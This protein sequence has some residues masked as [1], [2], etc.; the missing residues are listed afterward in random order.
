[1]QA[2]EIKDL[3][4]TFGGL[5]ALAEVNLGV[6]EWEIVGLIGPNGAGKTTLF[7]CMMGVY[8]PSSGDV[9]YNGGSISGLPT[10]KRA[11]LGLGRTFQNVGLAKRLTVLDNMLIA[12]HHK[13]NY[14]ALSGI[15]GSPSSIAEE[16]HLR[17]NAF[18]ILDYL[19]L[20]QYR[21]E[22]VSSLPYGLQ[23]LSEIAAVLASDPDVLLLDEPTSGMSPEEARAFGDLLLSLRRDLNL[24]VFMIEHHVP[25]VVAVCDYVYVLN[26]GRLLAEGK[27]KDIQRH[28]EVVAAYLGEE[29]AAS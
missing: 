18:E 15:F 24:T 22:R 27:P 17:D 5:Q 23:K 14:G 21:N 8:K 20:I 26:F 1:M 7:N 10:Y 19:G 16:R 3:G 2:I 25:L 4:I 9:L 6:N 12:Q 13:V 29:D 28:P 11:A